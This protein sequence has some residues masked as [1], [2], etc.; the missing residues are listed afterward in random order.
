MDRKTVFTKTAKGLREATGKTSVLPRDMRALLKEIDGKATYG[1]VLAKVGKMPEAKLQEALQVL[2][3]SDYIREFAP[4]ARVNASPQGPVAAD[5][6]LDFTAANPTVSTIARKAEEGAREKAQATA[7][8]EAVAKAK[9]EADARVKAAAAEA[10]ARAKAEAEAKAEADALSKAK[11]VAAALA[12]E[13]TKAEAAARAKRE[14]AEKARRE[15]EEKARQEAQQ[16]ARALEQARV[17]AEARARKEAEE[18]ARVETEL[19]TKLEEE[20]RA[21]EAAERRAKDEA[22]RQRKEA[23][24]KARREAEERARVEAELKARLE[25]ERKAREESERKAKEEAERQR[26]EAEERARVESELRA[27]LEEERKARE[28]TERKAKEEAERQ[29]KQAEEEVRRE[30]EE[31]ARVEAELRA[32]QQEERKAKEEAERQRKEAEERAW[33]ESE[34]RARVEAELRAKQEEERKAKEEA[35]RQ[36]IEA[37]ERSRRDA[38]ERARVEAELKARLEQ[39][40]KAREDAER[41]AREETERKTKEAAEH[42]RI[43]AVKKAQRE[44]EERTRIEIELKARQDEERKTREEAERKAREESERK[45]K[46]EAERARAE[47]EVRREADNLRARLEE[48]RQAREDAERRV[49]EEADRRAREDA[50]RE[51]REREALEAAERAVR[52]A[53]EHAVREAKEHAERE[54]KEHAVRVELENEERART[55]ATVQR[56]RK[57]DVVANKALAAD[58]ALAGAEAW[59]RGQVEAQTQIEAEMAETE[60]HFAEMERELEA[61]QAARKLQQPPE[62]PPDADTLSTDE[63]RV[64]VREKVAVHARDAKIAEEKAVRAHRAAV[65]WGRPVAIALFLLL[66]VGIA[67][68]HVVP[69]NGYIPQFEALASAQLQQPVKIKALHLSLLPLPHWRL[70]GVIAG[71]EG[72]FSAERIDAVAELGSMFAEKKAFS[73]IELVSPV[74]SEEALLALLFSKPQGQDFKVANIRVKGGKLSSKTFILP[75]LN[76]NISMGEDGAWQKMV[77]ETDDRKTN[78]LLEPKGEGVQLEV[79]TNVFAT[80]FGTA[81]LLENFSARGT[82]VRGELRLSEFK[83]GIFDG[84]LSG[85]AKLKWDPEWSL[86][87]EIS[88]RAMDPARIAPTLIEDGK[89]E[90]NAAYAMRAKSYDELFAA[91]QLEGSFTVRK[92]QLI[93]VDLARLL[94]GGGIGGKSA[95]TELTG[96]LVRNG[97]RTQLQ[98]LRLSAGP[99]SLSGNGEADARNNISGRFNVELKSPVAQARAVLVVSGSLKEPHFNR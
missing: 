37:E 90:G 96:N 69:L 15:A 86:G 98:Q 13:R 60:R 54:A 81:F 22:E 33:R 78:L 36:R 26:K 7:A 35:E 79:E 42:E 39:E 58:Q 88:V 2:A 74:L 77:L 38:E 10:A 57:D 63:S 87:G 94:Q 45:A 82:I 29:R 51:A 23:E 46:Q 48:E 43:E 20:R 3:E 25:E 11:A 84:Y 67:V 27:R 55:Q 95:F 34:E 12:A 61:E 8:A 50:A 1:E 24:E 91:P 18:R 73:T 85:S 89:L 53:K 28:E 80:P 97:G 56:R 62:L 64:R 52:E 76:A 65:N 40:R 75:A 6:D 16:H 21:R 83:G 70:D 30:A 59:E 49:R 72:Q 71:N 4:A 41:K 19:K 5:I 44:A 68:V 31:R 93:G 32:K 14:A 66:L 99:V 92:G 9:A 47:E 17:E